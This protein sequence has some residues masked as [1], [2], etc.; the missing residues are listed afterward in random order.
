MEVK[1]WEALDARPTPDWFKKAKFGIFIHWGPYA[2]PAFAPRRCEVSDTGSAYSEWYG[3]FV[4]EKRPAFVEYHRQHFGD[5]PYEDF[6][7]QLRGERFDPDQWAELF[8]A[9]GAKYVIA[10][11]KHHDSFTLF[12]SA[13]NRG[14]GSCQLGPKRDVL[15]EL[16]EACDRK[17]I[18]RGA[19]YSLLEW[20]FPVFTGKLQSQE[21]MEHYARTK[22]LP[23]MKQLVEDYRLQILYADGEWGFPSTVW[24][25]REFLTWLFEESSVRDTIAVNDRWGSDCRGVHGGYF[26]SEY[27]EVNSGAISEEEAR[28]NLMTH[29]WEECR[30]IGCS[31]G[32][33]RNERPEDYLSEDQLI[34]L[35]VHSVSGGG[36][37]CLNVGPKADGTIPDLVTQRL[38]GLG[39]WLEVNGEAIYES[40]S[41]PLNQADGL[42]RTRRGK[43]QYLFYFAVPKGIQRV[44]TEKAGIREVRLLGSACPVAFREENGSVEFELP[45]ELKVPCR[46]AYVVRLEND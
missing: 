43:Y 15:K 5:A 19:Y 35:L 46:H 14:Y 34:E 29:Y 8:Q 20:P 2:V 45:A 39:K 10:V 21:E 30:G 11:S 18:I 22:M 16:Y 23:E 6:A 12:D 1:N 32:Y 37:L 7:D 25:S 40:E 38:L 44:R 27:G 17:G 31:F 28:R 42:C 13:Y 4:R 9:S 33:N 36:N 3:W 41:S 26:T 24:H